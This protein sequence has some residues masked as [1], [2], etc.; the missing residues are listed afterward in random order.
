ML[1][2]VGA[3]GRRG[4]RY[5]RAR[6]RAGDLLFSRRFSGR[7]T[8][9]DD[10]RRRR[11]FN[12]TVRCNN[13]RRTRG[14]RARRRTCTRI[15]E[16]EREKNRRVKIHKR[17][18]LVQHRARIVYI[19]IMHSNGENRLDNTRRPIRRRHVSSL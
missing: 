6:A 5:N 17:A 18:R 1:L 3:V 16:R 15:G 11:V 4:K 10:V 9:A 14:R 8:R 19:Y 7:L 2:Q 13:V 12:I